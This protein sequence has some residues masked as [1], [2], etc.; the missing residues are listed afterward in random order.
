M[1]LHASIAG[2]MH[3][4]VTHLYGRTVDCNLLLPK[5]QK[6]L[7]LANL[8]ADAGL[9]IYVWSETE[10]CRF[11][12][13]PEHGSGLGFEHACCQLRCSLNG[14]NISKNEWSWLQDGDFLEIGLMRLQ[15]RLVG[16]TNTARQ[17]WKHDASFD[18]RHLA[19]VSVDEL[20]VCALGG[21]IRMEEDSRDTVSVEPGENDPL[22]QWNQRYL[23]RLKTPGAPFDEAKNWAVEKN[24][25][26]AKTQDPMGDLIAL[27]N[28]GPAIPEI[29]GQSDHINSVL[30]VLDDSG[31][32]P[33]SK[34]IEP[35]RVMH[36][37][38]PDG[39]RSPDVVFRLPALTRQEH[40]GMSLD[41]AIQTNSPKPPHE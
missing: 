16:T 3:I 14:R 18:L 38:A 17:K 11:H 19:K 28:Q 1:N 41:S 26:K 23:Q 15:V 37:F 2:D 9:E 22:S 32:D 36:L 39:Y 8:L 7:E 24:V 35:D 13:L 10:Q 33:L 12:V 27:A 29:L 6:I 21:L 31:G 20:H 25:A 5:Q 34:P 4:C 30:A 40:H